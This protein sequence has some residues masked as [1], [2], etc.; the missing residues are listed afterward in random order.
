MEINEVNL[1]KLGTDCERMGDRNLLKLVEMGCLVSGRVGKEGPKRKN[2]VLPWKKYIQ[3][4]QYEFF[5]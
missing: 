3:N 4:R 5:G 1:S 2:R